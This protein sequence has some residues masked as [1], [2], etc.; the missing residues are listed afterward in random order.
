MR[1][2]EPPRQRPDAACG[3]CQ[4]QKR[5]QDAARRAKR[6]PLN[7]RKPCRKPDKQQGQPCDKRHPDGARPSPDAARRI[8]VKGGRAQ[9]FRA[10]QGPK[11]E[12]QRG[13]RAVKGRL[14]QGGGIDGEGNGNGQLRRDEGGKHQRQHRA[15]SQ[16]QRQ[17]QQ[18]QQADLDEIGG[19]DRAPL[20]PQRLEGGDGLDLA[21]QIGAHGGRDADTAHRQPGQSHQHQKGTDPVDKGLHPRRAIAA[22]TP[23]QAGILKT[24]AGLGRKCRKVRPYRQGKAILAV[25]ERAGRQEPRAFQPCQRHDGAWPQPKAARG[26]IGFRHQCGAQFEFLRAQPK[27]IADLKRHPVDQK[28]VH[29]RAG[30]VGHGQRL[31]ERQGRVQHDRAVKRIGVIDAA[32]LCQPAL[33]PLRPVDH[34]HGA[35]IHRLGDAERDL[36]HIGALGFI[37]EAIGE[38]HLGIA[39][40]DACAFAGKPRLDRGAHRSDSGDGR[41]AQ[42]KA[43]QKNAKPLQPAAQFPLCDAPRDIHSAASLSGAPSI[44]PSRSR[45]SRSQRAASSG[46]CVT[47]TSVAP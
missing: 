1:P 16:P 33:G 23:T 11:R 26:A 29:H 22:V 30:P 43:S 9:L 14:G 19:K 34:D 2:R 36:V 45:I 27:D 15:Q 44:R 47:S 6:Q 46:A 17:P 21:L 4:K 25:I 28:P 10:R 5:A 12:D 20:G 8:A 39:T 18:R 32:H 3:K 40:K 37:G 38:A 13:Q 42:R 35:E 7:P 31:G 24:R 41:H